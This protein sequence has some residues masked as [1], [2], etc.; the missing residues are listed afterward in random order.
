MKYAVEVAHLLN[1]ELVSVRHLSTRRE[2]YGARL[3]AALVAGAFILGMAVV[4][5]VVRAFGR[6]VYAPEFLGLWLALGLL[7]IVFA[8][9][10][11][12]GRLGRYRLGTRLD[13]DGFAP[14]ELDLVRRVGH[15]ST[16]RRG[17][18]VASQD[19]AEA[20]EGFELTVVAGM[21]GSIENGRAPLP[22]EALVGA[23]SRVRSV[24]LA[25]DARAEVRVGPSLFV[26]R[27]VPLSHSVH[28]KV[29]RDFWRPFSRV[30]L[31]AL[32][33]AAVGTLLSI[34]PPPQTIGD[35]PRAS[36]PRITTPWEAEKRLRWEAQEQA[37]SLHQCFDP[38]PMSCQ[39]PG[40]VGVGVSLNRDGELRSNWI[41]RS[42]YGRECPVDQC[43]KDVV[44]T[45]IFDPLPEAMRVVLPVQV[46]RTEKPLP[47]KMARAEATV[48]AGQVGS[49][50]LAVEW[51][52]D[53]R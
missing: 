38:L 44:S 23:G 50:D 29:P 19:S 37:A 45:W 5:G 40:Y 28:G 11:V 36:G 53:G 24:R 1:G 30:A 15:G 35:R 12:S 9:V 8:H 39:H 32:E 17:R 41:A 6:A 49:G 27:T 2:R 3:A 21:Q 26:V 18:P 51:T 13:A 48:P 33:V 16:F 42:T 7:S 34:I 22:I 4:F 52:R 20:G 31:G 10:C 14:F 43:M 46:L 47:P 25:R